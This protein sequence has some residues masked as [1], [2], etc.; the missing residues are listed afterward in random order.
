MKR[1][2]MPVFFLLLGVVLLV[3]FFRMRSEHERLLQTEADLL[4]A[5][6][7]RA[8]EPSSGSVE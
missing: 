2:A 1:F 8:Q 7:V 5:E 4:N 3:G 6:K